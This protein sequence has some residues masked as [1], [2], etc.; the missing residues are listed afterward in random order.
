MEIEE[1]GTLDAPVPNE[2]KRALVPP[3][4]DEHPAYHRL[5]GQHLP[6][7]VPGQPAYNSLPSQR[8]LAPPS[9]SHVPEQSPK[10]PGLV[11]TPI[12]IS[13]GDTQLETIPITPKAELAASPVQPKPSSPIPSSKFSTARRSPP[14]SPP[15]TS[16]PM[17]P[18][19]LANVATIR[20]PPRENGPLTNFSMKHISI[21][22]PGY[23][24]PTAGGKVE[25]PASLPPTDAPAVNDAPV[26]APLNPTPAF[27]HIYLPEPLSG[28]ST[29]SMDTAYSTIPI[30]LGDDKSGSNTRSAN[31]REDQKQMKSSNLRHEHKRSPEMKQEKRSPKAGHEKKQSQQYSREQGSPPQAGQGKRRSPNVAREPRSSPPPKHQQEFT[32]PLPSILSDIHPALRDQVRQ[33]RGDTTPSKREKRSPPN[34]QPRSPPQEER[35]SPPP[36]RQQRSDVSAMSDS[37]YPLREQPSEMSMLTVSEQSESAP[38]KSKQKKK[39]WSASERDGMS[40]LVYKGDAPIGHDE[41]SP[42]FS[43][44]GTSRLAAQSNEESDMSIQPLA[45]QGREGW[46]AVPLTPMTPLN[47]TKAQKRAEGMF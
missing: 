11:F 2:E 34:Q 13:L 4:D 46:S 21:P 28:V 23:P 38:V 18:A 9:I 29:S 25:L 24:S 43:P 45:L 1:G 8:S 42:L 36:L 14:S 27:H 15:K 6:A 32:P 44:Q 7:Y 37:Y 5:P 31:A 20:S 35:R 41:V 19:P 22:K 33:E 30:G 26:K 12:D 39:K 17:S 3:P 47:K 10:I 16:L 40:L